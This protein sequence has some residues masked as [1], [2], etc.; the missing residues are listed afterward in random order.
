MHWPPWS[1]P[2][3]PTPPSK[4]E[5]PPTTATLSP[6]TS[7][8]S[9]PNLPTTWSAYL[10]PEVLLPTAI[11]TSTILISHR[12]YRL[13]LRRFP[14][15][16]TI[17]PSFWRKRSLFGTVTSVGDGDGFRLFHTPGGRLAGWGWFPGRRIPRGKALKDKTISIRLAGIDA[18]EGAHFGRPTQPGA[19]EALDFL[20]AYIQHRRVRAYVYKKDQYDRAVATVYVRRWGL[21]RDVGYQMLRRGLATVYEA[22]SGAEF[23]ALEE[24]YRQVEGW[25]RKK[26]KGIW[27]VKDGFE[28]PRD[29]KERMKGIEGKGN[30]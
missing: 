24:R 21:K 28:S 7:S 30:A 19:Q 6:H 27:A 2:P 17:A 20:T 14:R 5:N 15:A 29:Y 8:W 10:A 4:A 11:L 16:A 9:S 26:G 12:L 18:P 13:H 3:P 23:G 25:A 22:K 1:S